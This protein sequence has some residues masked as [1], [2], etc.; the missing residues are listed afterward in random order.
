MQYADFRAKVKKYPVINGALLK[1]LAAH[2]P[3]LRINL[4]RWRKKGKVIRLRRDAYVLNPDDS[5]LRPSRLF[6][7]KEMYGPSYISLEYALSVYDLIPER[8]AA[9]T[10]ITTK[11]TMT[12]HNEYGTFIYQHLKPNAFTGFKQQKDEAGL[13]YFMA[14]PEKAVVD[15]LYLNRNKIT[16]DYRNVL[17]ESYRWQN[18][19]ALDFNKL[20]DYASLFKNKKVTAI[21]QEL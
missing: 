12:F 19:E 8:T 1:V 6:L 3:G 16:G 10:S 2:S 21:L 18:L 17:L 4:Q 9:V 15:F 7:A 20:M 14:T 5:R 11:K 13:A